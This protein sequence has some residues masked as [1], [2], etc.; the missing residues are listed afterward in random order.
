MH[1]RP[2]ALPDGSAIAKRRYAWPEPRRLAQ[3]GA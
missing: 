2:A 1:L 3:G